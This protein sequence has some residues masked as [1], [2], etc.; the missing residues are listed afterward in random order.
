MTGNMQSIGRYLTISL[1]SSTFLGGLL[2]VKDA[3]IPILTNPLGLGYQ[4]YGYEQGSNILECM[5]RH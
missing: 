1:S 5:I 3:V 4:G 2:Y